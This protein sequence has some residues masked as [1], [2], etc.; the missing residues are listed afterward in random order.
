MLH[1]PPSHEINA[2]KELAGNPSVQFTESELDTLLSSHAIDQELKKMTA[3]GVLPSQRSMTAVVAD[4][5][6][7]IR[8]QDTK[9]QELQ[10]LQTADTEN[11]WVK[12]LTEDFITYEV[13]PSNSKEEAKVILE[14][15]NKELNLQAE[16]GFGAEARNY[17][18][19]LK[20]ELE[21]ILEKL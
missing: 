9:E 6:D 10:E 19:K 1:Q 7:A 3:K 8:W 15:L 5:T 20:K 11:L 21:I 13:S 18:E 14:N 4:L 2:K 12:D 17:V 16:A